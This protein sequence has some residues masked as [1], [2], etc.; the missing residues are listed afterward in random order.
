MKIFFRKV[1]VRNFLSFGDETTVFNYKTGIHVVTGSVLPGD[2]RNGAGKSSL[3]VDSI[4]FSLYGK[5]MRKVKKEN[6]INDINGKKCVVS[7][8]FDVGKKSYKI[9]RG[10]KPG[11]LK[12]W[13]TDSPMGESEP[14]FDDSTFIEFD[15]IKNTQEWLSR[16]VDISYESFIN[17]VV[18]NINHSKPFL[19]MD[20]KDKRPV[21]VDIINLGIYSKMG[22]IA[23]KNHLN[24]NG[25]VKGLTANLKTM[26]DNH[27]LNKEKRESLM[28]EVEH[29]EEEK[30]ERLEELR[31]KLN[32]S[33]TD[34][35]ELES[36]RT[37]TDYKKE[38][39]SLKRK[40]DAM[41]TK[42]NRIKSEIQDLR[43]TISDGE[44]A[45]SRLEHESECPLCKTPTDNPLVSKYIDDTKNLCTEA[46]TKIDKLQVGLD[47]GNTAHKKLKSL[48][49]STR[50]EQTEQTKLRSACEYNEKLIIQ[51]KEDIVAEEKRELDI[52]SVISEEDINEEA[53]AVKKYKKLFTDAKKDLDY[54]KFIRT[55]LGEDGIG[56]Y[57]IKKVLPF[58]NQKIIHYLGLLGSDYSL[59]FDQDLNE[60]LVN[61]NGMA[62]EYS[63]FS[64]GEKKRIDLSILMA[65]M[66]VAKN[67]N[68][69]DTNILILDE[70]L[71]TSMC[72]EG[73]ESFMLH[74][75]ESFQQ[76]YPDKC[77]YIIT[78]RKEIGEEV[79][80]SMIEVVKENGFTRLNIDK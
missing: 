24:A 54:N 39:L 16:K 19:E 67:Q 45:I 23:K 72:A 2:K 63:S 44:D 26:L 25:E 48:I 53:H 34:L 38:L 47:K 55:V 4:V 46:Q 27:K 75:K 73:V 14:V 28:K 71:D 32:S 69:I 10:I 8:E 33:E 17:M 29:F 7:C 68:S 35:L 36:K 70:V 77:V 40:E 22:V 59:V 62:K 61:K 9:E 30:A 42:I 64:A 20:L 49:E 12:A 15:S 37:H 41:V 1:T 56:K 51:L 74:L 79:Y 21:L 80:D 43:R 58:L 60:S 78:H 50:K 5:T 18:L 11:F 65:M 66:D 57:V 6:I 52:D 76:A 13:E 31:T 3:L